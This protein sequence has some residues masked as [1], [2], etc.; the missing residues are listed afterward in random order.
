[1][2]VKELIKQLQ[3]YDPYDIVILATDEEGNSFAPLDDISD[4]VY[5]AKYKE[6]HL[7]ELTPELEDRGFTE[8]DLYN[9]EDGQLAIVLWP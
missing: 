7:R 3:Q 4:V 9:G 2:I 8:E 6:T 5:V 1:M